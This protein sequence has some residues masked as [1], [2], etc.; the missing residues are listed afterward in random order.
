MITQICTSAAMLMRR[1]GPAAV[2]AIG[3]ALCACVVNP[4]PTP[5]TGKGIQFPGGGP[6]PPGNLTDVAQAGGGRKT[7]ERDAAAG[8][9]DRD[10]KSDAE[11]TAAAPDV[12]PDA[13]PPP[14]WDAAAADTF[15]AADAPA[16]AAV[17]DPDA[18]S[19]TGDTGAVDTLPVE[20][21]PA[22]DIQQQ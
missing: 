20:V 4:V 13:G 5:A 9:N 21:S 15:A 18:A 17:A 14:Y 16:D 3:L 6:V 7:N 22:A 10:R 11:A 12:M 19:P 8:F 2:A 1:L